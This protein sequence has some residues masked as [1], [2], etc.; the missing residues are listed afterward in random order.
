MALR[1]R[2]KKGITR[3]RYGFPLAPEVD[4]VYLDAIRYIG[5]SRTKDYETVVLEFRRGSKYLVDLNYF[6]GDMDYKDYDTYLKKTA[7]KKLKLE[8]LGHVFLNR[9]VMARIN[10]ESE[11]IDDYVN[12]LTKELEKVNCQETKLVIKTV[13]DKKGFI[14][15]PHLGDSIKLQGSEDKSF[16]YDDYESKNIESFKN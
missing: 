14:S 4:N 7:F 15:L 2:N 3:G 6:E 1:R 16:S 10:A 9:E 12:F 13:R 8:R 5:L 11:G